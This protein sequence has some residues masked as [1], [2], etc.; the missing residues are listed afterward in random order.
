MELWALMRLIS[1]ATRLPVEIV[2][3]IAEDIV[4]RLRIERLVR[5]RR[6]AWAYVNNAQTFLQVQSATNPFPI[7]LLY[8]PGY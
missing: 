5:R 6:Y 7:P 3:L 2:S 4:E 8:G 1:R